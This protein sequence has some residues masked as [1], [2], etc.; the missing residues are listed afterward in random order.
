ML[1]Y[2]TNALPHFLAYFGSALALAAG[3]LFL[4]SLV[5]PHPEFKLIREGNAAAA[6]QLC[7]TFIGFAIPVAI[8][9][10]H[11]VS[12]P[13]MLLWGLVAGVVQLLVFLIISRF[14]FKAIE[15]R[16]VQ[17]CT[18]SGQFVGGMGI[19]IGILQA[20]CMVP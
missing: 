12:I 8:V 2:F 18:A 14:L 15:E 7:G 10:G 9:I 6:T 13:D 1:D 5:T 16:I 11:S 19:G 3:F 17:G 20:A 4:Y